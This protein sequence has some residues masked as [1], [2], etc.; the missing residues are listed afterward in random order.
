MDDF[1]KCNYHTHTT[2]CKHAVNTDR[3]Y[4][5]TAISMGM[6]EL[7]FSDHIPCPF[8][9]GFVS[10]IRM[11]MGQADEYV[12]SLRALGREYAGRIR[13]LIG[14]EAEYISEFYDA[15]MEV[16]RRL[17]MDY[18]IMGQH[19]NHSEDH[20]IYAGVP[21]PGDAHIRDYVDAVI[22]G[23]QTGSYACLAHPDLIGYN[24][25]EATYEREITRLCTAMKD[26]D[27]P[28][29]INLCGIAQHK[30]FPADRFWRIAGHIGNKVILGVDA[31]AAY[32][33]TDRDSYRKAMDLVARHDLH[34]INTLKIK[35]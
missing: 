22:T 16:F 6:E 12:A 27:I 17:D 20:D 30:H 21:V 11:D 8:R 3:E 9:N 4:I 32:E 28:L 29:E 18:L 2:R 34:L 1:M 33:L 14:F 13:V 23:M 31:H 35:K 7:G 10:T 24:G 25:P 15:Q 5:E 19:F 26:M